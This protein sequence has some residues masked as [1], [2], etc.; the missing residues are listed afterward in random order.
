[1]CELC[2]KTFQSNKYLARHKRW[3]DGEYKCTRCDANFHDNSS[4]KSHITFI[5][6]GKLLEC[7]Q[8]DKKFKS[9]GGLRKHQQL[10][11]PKTQKCT[12]D[13]CDREFT[14]AAPLYY[15]REKYHR[16]DTSN[17][18][19]CGSCSKTFSSNSKLERHV[20]TH[21][22]LRP[23]TCETCQT[24]FKR[25]DSMVRH[26]STHTTVSC[27]MCGG[28]YKGQHQYKRHLKTKH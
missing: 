14:A 21:D 2:G 19:E 20:I 8:C 12:V 11:S 25:K 3:H 28:K 1:M 18:F 15:H 10:H 27:G 13:K 9:A 7:A 6:Y 17:F 24:T 5:H 22:N 26:M 16:K 23:F 4:L